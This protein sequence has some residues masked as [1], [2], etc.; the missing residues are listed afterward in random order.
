MRNLKKLTGILLIVTMMI[1]AFSLVPGAFASTSEIAYVNAAGEDMGVQS[2]TIITTKSTN[3]SN[4]W[5]DQ[6]W[7]NFRKCQIQLRTVTRYV[8]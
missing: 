8:I 3:W 2:C 6:L 1:A 4:G 5:Y 7:P